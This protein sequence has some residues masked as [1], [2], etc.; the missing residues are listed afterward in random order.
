MAEPSAIIGLVSAGLGLLAAFV[1]QVLPLLKKLLFKASSCQLPY[2][3][4]P[5]SIDQARYRL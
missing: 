5:H 2:E 4:T 1:N 3:I